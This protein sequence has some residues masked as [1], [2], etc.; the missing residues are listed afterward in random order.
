M[1]EKFF[2]RNPLFYPL[3]ETKKAQ[4]EPEI[5]KQVEI[6]T[7]KIPTK[8][9]PYQGVQFNNIQDAI[10]LLKLHEDIKVDPEL[11]V[12]NKI[13]FITAEIPKHRIIPAP[14]GAFF[15]SPHSDNPNYSLLIFFSKKNSLD[16][17]GLSIVPTNNQVFQK[18]EQDH[19][20]N[21]LTT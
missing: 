7:I 13:E 15:I 19:L 12:S 9:T 14:E 4:V 18:C 8:I 1:Y 17:L 11:K 16:E 5:Q 10:N 21:L 6:E 2:R 20:K 3:P